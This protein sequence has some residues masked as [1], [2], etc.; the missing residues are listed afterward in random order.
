MDTGDEIQ[1]LIQHRYAPFVKSDFLFPYL[2]HFGKVG[3]K[4]EG[5]MNP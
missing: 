3:V 5:N 4:M 1:H 2:L